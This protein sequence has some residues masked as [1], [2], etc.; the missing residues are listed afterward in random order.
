MRLISFVAA[1][2]MSAASL[3]ALAP[4]SPFDPPP[5]AVRR[6]TGK[7]APRPIDP[8][9][10]LAG[11]ERSPALPV[12]KR[13]AAE[14]SGELP[15]V[16]LKR[17]VDAL[18][19]EIKARPI[20]GATLPGTIAVRA[21]ANKQDWLKAAYDRNLVDAS[22]VGWM[23]ADKLIFA[24]TLKRELGAAE[25]ER[26]YP[27]TLG[28]KQF[29]ESRRLVD[30]RGRLKVDADAVEQALADE[31]PFGYVVKP[32]VGVAPGETERGLYARSDQ[33]VTELFAA[34]PTVYAP[35]TF[36]VPIRSHILGG[37]ASGEAIVLQ[38]DVVLRADARQRLRAR[39]MSIARVHSYEDRA[40][41]DSAPASWVRDDRLPTTSDA[42]RSEAFVSQMLGRLSAQLVAKQAWSLDVAAMDNGDLRVVDV[43]TNRG[44]PIAW[45]G[46]LDQ[47]R[48]IGAYSRL[49]EDRYG[50][51]FGGVS[52]ALLRA[53]L[54]N[55]LSYWGKR[56]E[57]AKAP[58]KKALA[59]LPPAP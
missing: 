26:F 46:Y 41:P 1:T 47:P 54:G 17:R 39:K 58:W 36:R 59:L 18:W 40:V 23:L 2:A 34:K 6:A 15:S 57:A 27:K 35:S 33:L 32:A 7:K 16:Y 31:F 52:G 45:S 11:D 48:V 13:L 55:Y 12:A 10:A 21:S 19:A 9:P 8:A 25:A 28:L 42:R 49:W 53:N 56:I 3:G 37:A 51:S 24:E 14:R 43:V 29:L 30:V 50:V 4:R 20:R 22:R 44:R 5:G 38:E